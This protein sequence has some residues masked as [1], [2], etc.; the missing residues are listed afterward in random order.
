LFRSIFPDGS[1]EEINLA[2]GSHSA[3]ME[4]GGVRVNIIPKSGGNLFKGSVFGSYTNHS[5]QSNNLSDDLKARGLPIADYVDSISDF[6]PTLGGPL[7]RDRLW[8]HVGYRVLR[9]FVNSAF[10]N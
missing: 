8:F 2:A 9:T 10:F 5:L 7:V 3:E 1:V 4:T 6:N